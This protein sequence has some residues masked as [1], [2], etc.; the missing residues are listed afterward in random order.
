MLN[1]LALLLILPHGNMFVTHLLSTYFVFVVSITKSR[2]SYRCLYWTDI[3]L[4]RIEKAS[5]D[6]T[7]RNI[8]INSTTFGV[9]TGITLDYST[10][11][12]YW[13]NTDRGI[14]CSNVNGSN[15]RVL[16]SATSYGYA[17]EFFRGNLYLTYN[18]IVHSISIMRPNSSMASYA[19]RSC[20]Q[21][22]DI[23]VISEEQQPLGI[24]LI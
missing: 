1:H 6:G 18:Q 23:K 10:Q 22:F 9:P 7:R 11:T 3:S 24:T 2:F 20:Q 8:I 5:M 16:V 13:T 14:E 4:A 19:F 15:R 21:I 12:L 17:I